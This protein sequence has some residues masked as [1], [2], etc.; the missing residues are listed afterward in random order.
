MNDRPAPQGHAEFGGF[1]GVT[2][3]DITPPVGIFSRNW[4]A[5]KHDIATGIHQPLSVTALTMQAARDAAPCV[6]VAGDICWWRTGSDEEYVRQ[7][8][9]DKTGLDAGRLMI[10]CSHSHSVPA[11]S[12]NDVD[13]PGGHLIPIYM[14]QVREAIAAAINIALQTAA[15]ATISWTTGRCDLARNRDLPD[16]DNA[17]R[18]IC[19]FN[20]ALPAD[21]TVLVG[22][23]TNEAG[24]IVATLVNY[25]CHPTTL[26]WD[27]ELISP[28]YIGAM[29]DVVE[30]HTNGAYCLFLQG[31]SGELAP[32]EDYDVGIA[33]TEAHG[34]RLGYAALAALEG[35]LPPR[36]RMEYS[37]VVESGAPLATWARVAHEPATALRA[38]HTVMDVKLKELPS[39]AEL[40]AQ[41]KNTDD[42]VM[43]ERIRR[44]LRVRQTIGEGTSTPIGVW[45]FR[46]GDVIFVGHPVEAYSNFQLELR[47]R[48]PHQAIIAMNVVNGTLGYFPPAELYGQDIYQ[49][50]QAPFAQGCL[51]QLIDTATSEINATLA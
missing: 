21:D 10:N 26:A 6:L 24:T 12:M 13:K 32:V 31:A 49:V 25:A 1:V 16:P 30:A 45:T 50:W 20:P 37:G 40:E 7:Y 9:L 5:A 33:V 11:M 39:S 19:G 18:V 48:F 4:G 22:R 46:A 34:R 2:R 3:A 15:P 27:N 8:V 14:D 29:R 35:M 41:L 23:I 36:T 42:R 51:E 44:K 17:D 47:R 38:R 43:S 28:D